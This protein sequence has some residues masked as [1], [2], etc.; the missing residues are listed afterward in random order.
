MQLSQEKSDAAGAGVEIGTERFVRDFPLAGVGLHRVAKPVAA[1]LIPDRVAAEAG[2]DRPR[3]VEE[4][5]A[6][7]GGRDHVEE[8]A[9]AATS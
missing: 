2:T 3:H 5:F 9:H 1:V 4:P 6:R 7:T 8:R